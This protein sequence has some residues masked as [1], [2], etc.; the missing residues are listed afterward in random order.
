MKI[1]ELERLNKLFFNVV[2]ISILNIVIAASVIT[3]FYSIP[4]HA[5]VQ[6]EAETK[7]HK[8]YLLHHDFEF[9][10]YTASPGDII[11]IINQSDI[12]HSVYIE[13]PDEKIINIDE[14]LYVQTPGVSVRWK[15]PESGE[16]LLRCWIHPVIHATLLISEPID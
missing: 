13:T 10:F 14:K 4:L 3:S 8:V 6:K 16:F 15:V 9:D 12:S 11:E 1:L 7:I 5:E 2:H